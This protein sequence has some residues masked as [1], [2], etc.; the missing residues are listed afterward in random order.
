MNILEAM[1]DPK[2]FGPHF[3]NPASWFAWRVFLR[4]LFGLPLVNDGQREVFKRCTGR[5]RPRPKGHT[6]A[7]LVCGRRSGKSYTLGLIAVYLAAFRD[8]RPYLARGEIGTIAIVATDRKQARQ[9]M[10]Y[11]RGLLK[12]TPMLARL[13]RSEG[14][15]VIELSNQVVLEVHSC[16]Y[17]RTRGYTLIAA[18]CDELAFW[19]TDEFAAEPDREVLAALR[20]ALSTI[21]GAMLLC[22]STPY[23]KRGALYDA[24]VKHHGKT[25]DPV[26]VW[27]APTKRMNPTVATSVID[28][29]MQRDEADAKAEW[30]A[31]FRSDL[32]SFIAR[33][34]VLACVDVGVC[35]RPPVAGIKYECFTDPSGGSADSMV[36]AIGHVENNIVVLDALREIKAPFDPDS[37]TAELVQLFRYYGCKL[38]NG[39]RY[40]AAWSAQAFEKRGVA[41]KHCDLPRTGLYLN[42][43]PHLNAKTIKLLDHTRAINQ[44]C[45]LERSTRRGAADSIDHPRNQH[46][47]V[48]NAIAGVAH[49][50]STRRKGSPAGWGYQVYAP[51]EWRK[52]AAEAAAQA[53][54]RD[55]VGPDGRIVPG[56][57][58]C[59]IDF[60]ALKRQRQLPE[61]LTRRPVCPPRIW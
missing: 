55:W 17:R 48:A 35:E 40:A 6:E 2:V 14:K 44:I 53:N 50:L 54:C 52:R 29:A 49:V 34:Q 11:M 47:D 5:S 15:E 59:T 28:E 9:I 10:N 57:R 13:I 31:Q 21:P 43:L 27:N 30:L 24:F 19:S 7:W 56:S 42:L 39:D 1:R 32:E 46:D 12:S 36:G 22:A 37:A 23:A 38:T 58:P 33:E 60:K 8:W 41:Y 45:S 61:G 3:P 16:S 26:L 20:P 4:T 18:L 25:G 51:P